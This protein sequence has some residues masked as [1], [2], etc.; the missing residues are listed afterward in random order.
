MAPCNT[1]PCTKKATRNYVY[2]SI[3][4]LRENDYELALF[5]YQKEALQRF[6]LVLVLSPAIQESG[7]SFGSVLFSPGYLV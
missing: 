1:N 4:H 6:D 2:S 5:W 3:Y 7:Q